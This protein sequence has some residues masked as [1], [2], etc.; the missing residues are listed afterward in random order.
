[1]SERVGAM[2]SATTHFG[3]TPTVCEGSGYE[4][5][6]YNVVAYLKQVRLGQGLSI[7]DVAQRSALPPSLIQ[8]MESGEF[9]NLPETLPKGTCLQRYADALGLKGAEIACGFSRRA[10][11]R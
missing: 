9:Q 7:T 1:M 4:D 10:S 6:L 2:E 8:A 11:A 5:R 3:A